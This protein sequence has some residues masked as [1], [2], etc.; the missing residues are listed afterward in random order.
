M[1]QNLPGQDLP[2]RKLSCM[3]LSI[4]DHHASTIPGSKPLADPLSRF[5]SG[6]FVHSFAAETSALKTCY[7]D[8]GKKMKAPRLHTTK[9]N[10]GSSKKNEGLLI[11]K[12]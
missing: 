12:E 8:Q 10:T 11:F 5:S 2:G 9:E 1:E 6:N 7:N 3:D 4:R